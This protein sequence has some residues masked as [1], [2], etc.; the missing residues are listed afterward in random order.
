MSL[1]TD[2]PYCLV[3]PTSYV[4]GVESDHFNTSN[5]PAGMSLHHCVCRAPLQFSNNDPKLRT[6]Y[7]GSHLI[8]PNGAQYNDQL[9]PSILE[10]WNHRSP[11]IDPAM[12]EPCLLEVVGDFKTMDPIFKGCYRDS[13]LYSEADLTQLRWQKVYLPVYQGEIPMPPAPY[14]QQVMEPAVTKQSPHRVEALDTSA[15][16]AKAKCSSIKDGPSWGFRHCSNTSTLKCP[17][18]TSTKKP[19]RPKDS[20]PDDQAKSPHAHSS[21]KCGRSPYPTSG[22]AGCK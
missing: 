17:N 12:G 20:T 15:E 19:S 8:L 13:L 11:L 4:K 18:S 3:Y 21:C 14:Y 10:L 16:S 22:S 7:I 2:P 6:Q 1:P 9:Y 5:S